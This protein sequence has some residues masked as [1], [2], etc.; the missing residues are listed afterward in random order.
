MTKLGVSFT[1]VTVIETVAGSEV[2]VP[3]VAVL[4]VLATYLLSPLNG[5]IRYEAL[6]AAAEGPFRSEGQGALAGHVAGCHIWAGTKNV[7]AS[8]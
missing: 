3:S 7:S 6:I 8:G 2:A 1:A 4:G 5:N